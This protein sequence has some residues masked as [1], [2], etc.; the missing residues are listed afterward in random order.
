MK[1]IHLE[2]EI[3]CD[4]DAFWKV[5]LDREY[6]EKLFR[7]VLGFPHFEILEEKDEEGVLR[8]E[9]AAQ[10]KLP[11]AQMALAR[12]LRRRGFHFIERGQFEKKARTWTWELEPNVW[13]SLLTNRGK[14]TVQPVGEGRVR[15][16]VD[17]EIAANIPA[18]GGM[19]EGSAVNRMHDGWNDSA[20]FMNEWIASRPKTAS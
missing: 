16:V 15:R 5:F 18:V 9:C 19:I 10:P 12:L 20:R 8:R 3:A 17:I 4:E 2:H 1:S 7:E 13:A 11:A 6:T 14:V